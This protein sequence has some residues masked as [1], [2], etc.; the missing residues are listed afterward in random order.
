MKQFSR[1]TLCR[2]AF[3]ALCA[4]PTLLVAVWILSRAVFGDGS[5]RRENW[6]QELS[7]RLGM[8]FII[9]AVTY[10]EFGVTELQQ[11]EVHDAE[12]GQL[13]ARAAAIEVTKST[14]GY[15]I[16]AVAP[17]IEAAQLGRLSHILH[18]RLMCQGSG[19]ERCEIS[20]S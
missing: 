12:T 4:A 8:K 9:G 19:G 7:S 15:L 2:G 10:P 14:D 6:E 20:A 5:L 13:V 16:E 3:L 1:K 11:V 17:E 18:E